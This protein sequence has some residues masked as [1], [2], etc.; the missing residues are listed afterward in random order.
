MHKW[1]KASDGVLRTHITLRPCVC[2]GTTVHCS[3]YALT[4]HLLSFIYK[5]YHYGGPR[6][7]ARA[8]G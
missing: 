1:G 3:N 2:V 8:H 4:M 7:D 5:A 6:G